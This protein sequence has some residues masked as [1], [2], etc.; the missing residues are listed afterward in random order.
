MLI[1]K[2]KIWIKRS[3]SEMAEL[4]Q[5]P[6]SP[7]YLALPT[8]RPVPSCY[9]QG[10]AL[11]LLEYVLTLQLPERLL[12]APSPIKSCSFSVLTI[13]IV[14]PHLAHQWFKDTYE[15]VFIKRIFKLI[16]RSKKIHLTARITPLLQFPH[17]PRRKTATFLKYL[18]RS[19]KAATQ[20]FKWKR[21]K[22][23][24]L[25]SVLFWAF[26]TWSLTYLSKY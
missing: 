10:A 8:P 23:S 6:W 12:P 15:S 21:T 17:R 2:N 13:F 18:I 5:G 16:V 11:S 7:Q 24:L 4:T 20:T 25:S 3:K 1:N 26:I 22:M 19:L 14:M 9:P